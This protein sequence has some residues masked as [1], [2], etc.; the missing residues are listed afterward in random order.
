MSVQKN[1]GRSGRGA[2]RS[3]PRTIDLEATQVKDIQ[4]EEETVQS[5]EGLEID[6]VATHGNEASETS[7]A[8]NESS[9]QDTAG[10]AV[11]AA[12]QDKARI[13]AGKDG[14]SNLLRMVASGLVGGAVSMLLLGGLERAGVPLLSSL[15]G[16]NQTS[17]TQSASESELVSGLTARIDMLEKQLSLSEPAQAIPQALVELP[18]QV[19]EKFNA[20]SQRLKELEERPAADHGAAPNGETASGLAELARQLATLRED[21]TGRESQS[22]SELVAME[23]KIANLITRLEATEGSQ[24]ALEKKLAETVTNPAPSEEEKL[25]RAMAATALKAAYQRGED[26][27]T[28]LA[29]AETLT[30]PGEA[31]SRLR[32]LAGSGMATLDGIKADFDSTAD[33]I[34]AGEDQ[35]QGG[36]M[37]QLIANA[38]S[39][40]KIRPAGPQPGDSVAAIVSRVQAGLAEGNLTQALAEWES[41]P[42]AGKVASENWAA[43][44]RSRVEADALVETVASQLAQGS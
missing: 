6:P 2:R 28:L 27:T 34:L 26:I 16:F 20:V 3:T 38:K 24:G 12:G 41:L 19:E 37:A 44:L 8:P 18:V 1:R 35:A 17:S 15:A 43:G 7:A 33:R 9:P 29:D 32:E 10:E 21:M 13:S 14:A 25:A 30:G 22:A 11:S 4:A 39:L 23:Q 5:S 40:V 31:I 36:T 42:E